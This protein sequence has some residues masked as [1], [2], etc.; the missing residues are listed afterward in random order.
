ME[1]ILDYNEFVSINEKLVY[2]NGKKKSVR[3]K[4][5][6]EVGYLEMVSVIGVG[7]F[8]AKFDSGNGSVSSITYDTYKIDGDYVIWTL[9]GIT[10]RSKKI[11]ESVVANKNN[12]K[13]IGIELD[14]EFNGVKYEKIPFT[15][16]NRKNNYAKI[17]VNRTFINTIHGV[18]NTS[19]S[20]IVTEKPED[21]SVNN[22]DKYSGIAFN[23]DDEDE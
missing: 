3:K 17:L 21:F 2:D 19:R 7:D 6:L 4:S 16:A 8:V 12:E 10:T 22:K 18:V 9:N 11:K 14:V 13:R 20:F 23:K 15:L 5:Y 1:H